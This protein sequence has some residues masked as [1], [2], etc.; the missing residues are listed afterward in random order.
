MTSTCC[1]CFISPSEKYFKVLLHGEKLHI[2]KNVSDSLYL[3]QNGNPREVPDILEH[4]CCPLIL[5]I[6]FTF[7]EAKFISNLKTKFIKTKKQLNLE[8]K[9]A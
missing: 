8:T 1:G 9:T 4:S 2:L 5:K 7:Q 3:T 6:L